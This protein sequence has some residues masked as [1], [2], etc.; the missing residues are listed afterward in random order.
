V[1][2]AERKLRRCHPEESEAT[3]GSTRIRRVKGIARLG[4]VDPSLPFGLARD[5]SGALLVLGKGLA[6]SSV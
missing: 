6:R 3:E 4:Q 5:D 1:T 2:A